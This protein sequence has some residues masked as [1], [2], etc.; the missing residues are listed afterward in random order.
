[1]S[2]SVTLDGSRVRDVAFDGDSCSIGRA[3]A[4]MM[5]DLV[6]GLTR[7]EIAAMAE[8]VKALVAGDPA[9]LAATEGDLRALAEVR[10]TP[11]RAACALLAWDA[12][13]DALASTHR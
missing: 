2:V 13:L 4:S 7:T 11:A 1:M 3:S 10:R 9:A 6:T 5:T 8:H 12:L